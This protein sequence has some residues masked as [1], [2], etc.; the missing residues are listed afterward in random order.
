MNIG[1]ST[2]SR[3]GHLQLGI[4]CALIVLCLGGGSL[5]SQTMDTLR[6]DSV[7]INEHLVVTAYRQTKEAFPLPLTFHSSTKFELAERWS[8]TVPEMLM[9]LP[10]VF[11]QKTTHGAGSPIIRG[12]TGQ[13]T[14]LMVDGIRINNAT[15]RSG[16]N[17]YLNTIDPSWV[18][19]LEYMPGSG[20]SEYGSDAI[21]GVLNVITADPQMTSYFKVAPE[22]NVRYTSKG[23]EK[24]AQAA[25]NL[26]SQ[27][28]ALRIGS[29]FRD[30]GDL[31][32]GASVGRQSPSGYNQKAGEAK[33][34]V[35]LRSDLRFVAAWQYLQQDTVPLYY[36]VALENFEYYQFA[37]QARQLLY[38]KLQYST[39]KKWLKS[40][41]FIV[42]Q[43]DCRETRLSA[44]RNQLKRLEEKDRIIT[45]GFQL[46]AL[47]TVSNRWKMTSGVESYYDK[48][49]SK[50]V[51]T[52]LNSNS[53][54]EKRGLYPDKSQ[55]ESWAF[56]NT[57]TIDIKRFQVSGGWRYNLF[58]LQVQEEQLGLTT[59]KPNALVGNIGASV[60]LFN[61]LRLFG[62]V[63]TAF[64][65]PNID[66][67]GTLGIVG[68][69]YELPNYQLQP[70][71]SRNMELGM[72]WKSKSA[73]A[74][75]S[76]YQILLNGLIGR[77]LSGDSIAG[78][79]VYL[80]ENIASAIVKGGDLQAEV[81]LNSS[82]VLKG[83]IGYTFG[84]NTITKEP[85]RR[86][87]PLYGRAEL[88]YKFSKGLV[89]LEGLAA[90]A[91]TRLA[92]A[93]QEDLRI[94]KEGTPKWSVLNLGYVQYLGQFTYCFEFHNLLDR[95]YKTHGSGVYAPGRSLW[96]QLSFQ[97]K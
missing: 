95:T 53:S 78:Y 46:Q 66:D 35:A 15:F 89:R 37:P 54:L 42:S 97:L 75:L 51:E 29:S 96:I 8:R 62:N 63:G 60:R 86:I 3:Y 65:S 84:E 94:G 28:W 38:G 43:Q 18:Q 32:G 50:Q 55:M 79:P 67:L 72:K 23:M 16:P 74:Q 44:R 70:E 90:K 52:E 88:Q 1:N 6:L 92:K 47:T 76:A 10:G 81:Q 82:W 5:Y 21:S 2:R 49:L 13:Q 25:I 85:L 73:S 45:N 24:S 69:R 59:I 71:K 68:Q 7:I 61:Q 87:P 83:N 9:G 26:S 14:L 31:V 12:L 77:V 27:K 57:H 19:K 58:K 4:E 40:L 91:Q 93:D 33:L 17:Q 39:R 36:R 11:V 22:V 30:F 20:S 80:K 34:N 56:F 48:V 64:R 41:Q